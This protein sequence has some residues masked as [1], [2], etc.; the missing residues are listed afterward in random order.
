MVR[1]IFDPTIG[2]A[3]RH[4]D[5]LPDMKPGNPHRKR[6]FTQTKAPTGPTGAV[7]LIA[8][9]FLANPVRI[10]LAIAPLHVGNNAFKHAGDLIDAPTFVIAERDFLIP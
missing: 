7:V 3:D 8:F 9:E 1:G 4:L 10:R 2:L 5:H 6:L